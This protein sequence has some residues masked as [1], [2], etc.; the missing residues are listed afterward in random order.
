MKKNT[1]ESQFHASC[2]VQM[3]YN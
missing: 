3:R 2:W 1:A